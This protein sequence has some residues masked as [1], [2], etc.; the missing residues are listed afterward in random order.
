M[1]LNVTP[2]G[3]K[4]SLLFPF[5]M[6]ILTSVLENFTKGLYKSNFYSTMY[7]RKFHEFILSKTH[8]TRLF[9]K[10]VTI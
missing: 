1:T 8:K 10:L 5:K 3:A 9:K 2:K 4:S 6:C 7:L